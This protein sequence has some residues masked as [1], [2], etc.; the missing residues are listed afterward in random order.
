MPVS[1]FLSADM[2]AM[3]NVKVPMRDGVNLSA[4]IYFPG[5]RRGHSR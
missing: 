3:Y 2:E 5:T 1:V 4:D